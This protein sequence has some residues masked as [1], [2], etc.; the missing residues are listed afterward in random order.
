LYLILMYETVSYCFFIFLYLS[1]QIKSIN[2]SKNENAL[3]ET[4]PKTHSFI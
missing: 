2:Q 1:G 4:Q 3:V